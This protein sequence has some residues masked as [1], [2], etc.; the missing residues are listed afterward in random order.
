MTPAID[1]WALGVVMFTFFTD[2][3]PF[4]D[5]C[6]ENNLM[7]IAGVVGI[8]KIIKMQEKYRF[9]IQKEYFDLVEDHKKHPTKYQGKSL[10]GLIPHDRR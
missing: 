9:S 10:K 7:A 8:D 6:K 5:E 1:I 3:K 2:K 4:Y